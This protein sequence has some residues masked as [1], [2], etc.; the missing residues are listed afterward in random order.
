MSDARRG[1]AALA[2]VVVGCGGSNAPPASPTGYEI[3]LTAPSSSV[4]EPSPVPA[5]PSSVPP[6]PPAVVEGSE[7]IDGVTVVRLS[8]ATV[9]ALRPDTPVR[10]PANAPVLIQI[11][12]DFECPFC[13]DTVPLV[14]ELERQFGAQ[15]RVAWRAFPLPGHAHSRQAA[16]AALSVLHERGP[17]AFWKAHDALFS[18]AANGLDQRDID[19]VVTSSGA[20]VDDYH[21]ALAERAYDRSVDTDMAAGD[22]IP[23]EGT[24]SILVGRYYVFGIAPLSVYAGLIERTVAEKRPR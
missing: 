21:R 16:A 19:A 2:L 17:E 6:A 22:A 8:A 23:I 20:D 24:P 14:A 11:W 18:T 15:I 12:S 3:D 7:T 10:G 1:F 5:P 9:P 4:E 13:A